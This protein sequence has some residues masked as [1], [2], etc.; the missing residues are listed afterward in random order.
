MNIEDIIK[1]I[2]VKASE[3]VTAPYLQLQTTYEQKGIVRERVFCYELYHQIRNLDKEQ[4]NL[5]LN[6]EIDK[7]GHIDFLKKERRNPDFVF[8]IPGNHINNTLVLE[9]KG[10]IVNGILKDFETL[11]LFTNKYK[12]KAGIF[13]L[14]NHSISELKKKYASKIKILSN[15]FKSIDNIYIITLPEAT[16]IES[17]EQ[18]KNILNE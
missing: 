4:T 5:V 8:H 6:G 11:L 10:K 7:R 12:Y 13:L 2:I 9:I 1:N 18:L 16:K 14:Y 15:N 17:I 3:K